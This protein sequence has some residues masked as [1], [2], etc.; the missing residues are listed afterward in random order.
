MFCEQKCLSL[1]T[2]IV[3]G[4]KLRYCLLVV[5]SLGL[6]SAHARLHEN[7]TTNQPF[8]SR[9][10]D[11]LYLFKSRLDSIPTG[12]FQQTAIYQDLVRKFGDNA[13]LASDFSRLFLPMTFYHSPA[14]DLLSIQKEGDIENIVKENVDLAL[15]NVYLKHPEWL[16]STES[17]LARVNTRISTEPTRQRADLDIVKQVAP[18]PQDVDIIPFDV[19]V[20][21]PNFWTFG[22]DYYMQFLQNYVSSN[23]YKGGESSYSMVGSM[24]MQATY[25]NKQKVRWDNKLELKLGFI[26]SRGDSLHKFKTSEDLIRYT[27]KLGLQASKRWYYTF[28]LLTYTQFTKGYKSNQSKVYSDFMSPFVVNLSLGMDYSLSWFHKHLNGTVHLAPLAGNFKYVGRTGLESSYGLDEGKHSLTDYGSEFTAD[29]TWKF[30]DNISW[31]TRLYGYTT[32]SRS[33]LEWENTFSFK[34]NRFI[35]SNIF[36]YPR[37]DDSTSRD[38]HHGYWQFKEYASLGFSFSF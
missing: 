38:D 14:H 24:T 35:S 20:R 2:L 16:E 4:M 9:Y 11:S 28:Q 27:G 7:V 36:V 23:W 21:K 19:M 5:F 22:G 6:V 8:T 37:F 25:N 29:L 30:S 15:M 18:R 32:Y 1:P 12:S 13:F 10:L 17:A 31:K 26:T 33:E 34:F 3:K